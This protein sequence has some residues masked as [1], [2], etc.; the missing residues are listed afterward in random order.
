MVAGGWW[1]VVWWWVVFGGV[2]RGEKN[3]IKKIMTET[4]KI[5]TNKSFYHKIFKT[6]K[7][8]SKFMTKVLGYKKLTP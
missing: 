5:M 3:V 4:N 2:V 7:V 6:A 1:W 8:C